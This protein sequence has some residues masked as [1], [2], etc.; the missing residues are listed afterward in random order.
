MNKYAALI[1][2]F[3]FAVSSIRS[4]EHATAETPIPKPSVP[5]FTV[6]FTDSSYVTPTTYSTDPYTRENITHYGIYVANK[7]IELKIRNRDFTAYYDEAISWNISLY[8]NIRMKVHSEE[9]WTQLYTNDTLPTMSISNY[10]V[11]S[12]TSMQ[13][14]SQNDYI[15]GTKI[16]ELL[17]GSQK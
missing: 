10:T 13:P 5:D 8:Y 7:T 11:F 16:I 14:D 12:Y 1:L 9:N 2:I 3:V 15:M 17:P 4:V 6:K